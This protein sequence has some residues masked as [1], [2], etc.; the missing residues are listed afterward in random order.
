MWDVRVF[1]TI[2]GDYQFTVD[3]A[4]AYWTTRLNGTSTSQVR[5]PLRGQGFS[6]AFSRGLFAVNARTVA[7]V[8]T[9]TG[10]VMS[11]GFITKTVYD[12]TDG[13]L[14]VNTADIRDLFKQRMGFGVGSWN[15]TGTL[16]VTNR[17]RSGAARAIVSRAM[18]DGAE[19]AWALP[20]DLPTDGSGTITRTW[21]YYR[22][23]TMHDLLVEIEDTGAEVWFDPYLS[24]GNLRWATRVG[25]PYTSGTADLPISPNDTAAS[26][27][28]VTT[29]GSQ[30]LT[31][32]IY[33]G[34]G[35][36]ADTLTAWAGEGPYTIPIRDAYRT[37]KDV[38][39][40][41][42]LQRV[43]DA[44]FAEHRDPTVQWTLTVDMNGDVTPA[45]VRPGRILRTITKG[46]EWIPDG[47]TEQRVIGVSGTLD[48]TVTPEVQA[49]G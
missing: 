20:I 40:L 23:L 26:G 30:Q 29:D 31:G 9:A 18:R 3:A 24:G 15:T 14:T 2:T 7:V 22:F 34:N 43:A 36:E 21:E 39:Q 37:Q 28:K 44:D 38:D 4:D 12:R 10:V 5:V 6:S 32:V 25:A 16:T 46:D 48:S 11:A 45:Q 27:V 33:G 42:Q 17:T 19:P 13:V 1:D 8:H 49:Y 41:A 35:T 47:I